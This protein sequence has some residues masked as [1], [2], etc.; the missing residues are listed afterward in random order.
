ME[1]MDQS[2]STNHVCLSNQVTGTAHNPD[3]KLKLRP[4]HV[5]FVLGRQLNMN[6]QRCRKLDGHISSVLFK[7]MFLWIRLAASFPPSQ[8][9]SLLVRD[10]SVLKR[11]VSANKRRTTHNIKL[12][13]PSRKDSVVTRFFV[14]FHFSPMTNLAAVQIFLYVTS[15]TSSTW[16]L[17]VLHHLRF[18]I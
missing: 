9:W 6:W 7:Q 5:G 17:I 12:H 10:L 16:I 3:L 1:R 13:F 2:S 18:A 11:T 15:V 14:S 8:T 4:Q